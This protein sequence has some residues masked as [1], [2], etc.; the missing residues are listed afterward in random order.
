MELAKWKARNAI[1]QC[2]QPTLEFRDPA[3]PLR[4][5]AEGGYRVQWQYALTSCL[6]SPPP[7]PSQGGCLWER[8][9]ES[10][11]SL[12]I[13]SFQYLCSTRNEHWIQWMGWLSWNALFSF[14]WALSL[15]FFLLF[16]YLDAFYH[17]SLTCWRY[18][19]K[20]ILLTHLQDELCKCKV[21]SKQYS[22]I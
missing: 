10:T 14:F 1:I 17:L 12:V 7:L 20:D 8:S 11:N 18:I 13:T 9:R 6:T 3:V 21:R 22:V 2:P 16:L 15:H 19:Y 5:S 4:H